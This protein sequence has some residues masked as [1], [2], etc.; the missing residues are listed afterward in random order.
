MNVRYRKR[1]ADL[2]LMPVP[3]S[4][5]EKDPAKIF[6]LRR[7]VIR[8]DQGLVQQLT[9]LVALV[10]CQNNTVVCPEG[11]FYPDDAMV[12][13]KNPHGRAHPT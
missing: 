12:R 10:A 6:D 3:D 5:D 2:K 9:T 8:A 1:E 13:S 11:L 4:K 7:I